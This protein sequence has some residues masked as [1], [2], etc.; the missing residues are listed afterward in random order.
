M[1]FANGK[2]KESNMKLTG[3]CIC[4][5]KEL[6]IDGICVECYNKNRKGGK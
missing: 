6:F 5:G 4:C 1:S 2:K 3:K